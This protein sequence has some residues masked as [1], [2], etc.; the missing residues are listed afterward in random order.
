MNRKPTSMKT[1]SRN[2]RLDALRHAAGE[3]AAYLIQAADGLHDLE[4]LRPRG[5]E[6]GPAG[7]AGR[8]RSPPPAPRR[9]PGRRPWAGHRVRVAGRGH[10]GPATG[11]RRHAGPC[12]R[13]AKIAAQGAPPR[14]LRIRRGRPS[15]FG[16]KPPLGWLSGGDQGSRALPASG[17][18]PRH[19]PGMA[20]D[21]PGKRQ[22]AREDPRV[23]ACEPAPANVAS[24]LGL[25]G[26]L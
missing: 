1:A 8:R 20:Q 18:P 14:L 19:R 10:G 24:I 7:D 17:S 16:L 12:C 2:D 23:V 6:R 9:P 22:D 25:L 21:P 11:T 4:D 26:W 13:A 15:S 5:R 3:G